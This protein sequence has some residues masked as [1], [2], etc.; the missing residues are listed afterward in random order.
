MVAVGRVVA[1]ARPCQGHLRPSILTAGFSAGGK[2]S[3]RMH[4]S[5]L[6]D[7]FSRLAARVG[8]SGAIAGRRS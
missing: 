3:K 8:V 5:V 2:V 6:K 4:E 1:T 7:R